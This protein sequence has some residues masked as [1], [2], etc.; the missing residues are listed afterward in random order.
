MTTEGTWPDPAVLA[1]AA[2]D[3][4]VDDDAW[5]AEPSHREHHHS[6]ATDDDLP[7][8]V[9]RFEQHTG[10]I[11]ANRDPLTGLPNRDVLVDRAEHALARLARRPGTCVALFI[12]FDQFKAVND[13]F[14][15]RDGDVLLAALARQLTSVVRPADTLARVGGDE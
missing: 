6:A 3:A 15:H 8:A 14:G 11:E 10:A 5:L 13:R 12:D 4:V 9:I 2:D 1:L 7:V